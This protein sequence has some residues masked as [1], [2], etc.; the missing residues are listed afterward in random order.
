MARLSKTRK[1]KTNKPA[2]DNNA[3]VFSWKSWKKK[4]KFMKFTSPIKTTKKKRS[5]RKQRITVQDFDDMIVRSA[6][7]RSKKKH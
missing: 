1:N 4:R 2:L 3:D 7:F 5:H 6:L